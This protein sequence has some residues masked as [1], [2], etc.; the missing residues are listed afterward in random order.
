ME[1]GCALHSLQRVHGLPSPES[2]FL[3]TAIVNDTGALELLSDG[4]T[5]LDLRKATITGT[6]AVSGLTSSHDDLLNLAN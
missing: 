6:G 5:I 4:S 2:K 3:Y 1:A